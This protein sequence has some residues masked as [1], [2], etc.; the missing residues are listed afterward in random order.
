MILKYQFSLKESRIPWIAVPGLQQELYKLNVEFL[1]IPYSNVVIKDHDK[2]HIKRMQEHTHV[3]RLPLAN[4]ETI[5]IPIKTL[6][7]KVKSS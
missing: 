7:E 5:R 4:D 3:K 1:V 6:T 2:G